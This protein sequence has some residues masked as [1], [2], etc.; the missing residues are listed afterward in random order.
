[1]IHTNTILKNSLHLSDSEH[2]TVCQDVEG[3]EQCGRGDGRETGDKRS[4]R[5]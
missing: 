5:R 3:E 4:E 1:M 2:I